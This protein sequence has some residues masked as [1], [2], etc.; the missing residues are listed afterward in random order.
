MKIIQVLAALLLFGGLSY[1]IA[2]KI[3]AMRDD[4]CENE[5]LPTAIQLENQLTMDINRH[6]DN[7][8]ELALL[9]QA[10]QGPT[11]VHMSNSGASTPS[12]KC[13]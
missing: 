9:Q 10:A 11:L 7:L 8:R 2:Q 5:S 6:K 13:C 1:F 12:N 3:K 4:K